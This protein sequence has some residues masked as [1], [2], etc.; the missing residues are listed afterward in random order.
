MTPGLLSGDWMIGRGLRQR[1]Q[2]RDHLPDRL[3]ELR[4][5]AVGLAGGVALDQDVLAVGLLHDGLG[6]HPL[7]LARLARGRSY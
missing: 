2:R 1:P 3:P 5:L 6:Q 7:G 4:I